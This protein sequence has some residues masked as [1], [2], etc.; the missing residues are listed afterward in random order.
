[1]EITKQQ[2]KSILEKAPVGT[3]PQA[4]VEG[5][6]KRGY[7]LEGLDPLTTAAFREQ[8]NLTETTAGNQF[9]QKPQGFWQ[10]A[11]NFAANVIGGGK[12]AEGLG[13]AIAAPS[14][15]NSLDDAYTNLANQQTDLL[16]KLK[17]QRANGEDTSRT[18]NLLKLNQ[19]DIEKIAD[20]NSDFA[21]SLVSD[22]QVVGSAARLAGTIA[23]GSLVGGVS[24]GGTGTLQAA[25][26]LEKA[27]GVSQL[28]GAGK[29][30]TIT[31]GA[32]RGLGAGATTGAVE[33]GVQGAGMAAEANKTTEELLISGALGAVG[34]AVIGGAVGTVAGG[35]TGGL[36]G[37]KLRAEQFA[38]D[39]ASPKTT[40]KMRAE[41]IRQGRLTDPTFLG[42]AEIQ[43]SKRDKIV[44]DAIDDVVSPKATIGENI[45]AI[46]SKIDQT[47]AGVRAYITRNKVPFNSNQLRSRLMAGNEDL[48][49]IFASDSNAQ[50]TYNAVV[51]AFMDNV[52]KKDTLGLFEGRQTFDQLPAIK[53]LLQSD[54]LGENAR[55]E[56]SLSVRRAANEYI[57]DLL[58]K[59]NQYAN[60]MRNQSY[61]LEALGN[62]AEKS[63]NII[64]KNNLQLLAQ[65]YP[66]IKW[67][68]G[69]GA[70]GLVG[71]AGVGVGASIVGSSD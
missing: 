26:G 49:L 28:F 39:L 42:K 40:P 63:E 29:A 43:F 64:G 56:I 15:L 14:A 2:F 20:A 10:K 68:I 34:G 37:R 44:A 51:D 33:G 3:N 6:V 22:K 13:Q 52:G 55:K 8:A 21:E 1:M 62:L 45:G 4:L 60:S 46:R 16:M 41:A 30:T 7:N 32:L 67:L 61:A 12:L 17:D 25:K 71:A 35:V 23:G 36:K 70:T 48:K 50:K 24:R 9:E 69:A 31:G 54:V 11:Q 65:E 66:Y 19:A 47:D 57:A 5:L 38:Q 59:G 58:P 27:G 53:K 18:M